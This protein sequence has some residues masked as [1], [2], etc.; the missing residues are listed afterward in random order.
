MTMLPLPLSFARPG[1]K[2]LAYV[3]WWFIRRAWRWIGFVA[4][5]VATGVGLGE[6]LKR[7]K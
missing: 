5:L 3:R 4:L 2:G 7:L 6:G 1:T